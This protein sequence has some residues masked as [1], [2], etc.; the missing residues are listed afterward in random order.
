MK[1]V[2]AVLKHVCAVL[3]SIFALCPLS[4]AQFIADN[5]VVSS[6]SE[7]ATNSNEPQVCPLGPAPAAPW[8]KEN[9]Q[10]FGHI[11]GNVLARLKNTSEELIS[12][13]HDS[14]LTQSGVDPLW[15]GEYFSAGNGAPQM[16]FGV[17]CVFHSDDVP[18]NPPCD[19]TIFAN[20]ISPLI[21]SLAV[22]GHAYVTLKGFTGGNP[23]FEFDLPARGD[24]A[25]T[26]TVAV[27]VKAWLVAAD[28]NLLPY[29]PV[30][31]K[32]YLEQAQQE[33]NG[34]K[35]SLIAD[36]KSR[37]QV[38]PAAEQET[39]K[40]QS[41]EQLRNTYSGAELQ[42]R[43]R[44]FLSSYKTDEEYM[45]E[46]VTAATE[47]LDRTLALIGKLLSGSSAQQLAQPAVVS[48]PSLEFHGFEDGR[49]G[50]TVL[51]RLRSAYYSDDADQ[52]KSLLIC[53]RYRPSD[54]MAAAID[55]Q[56]SMRN[57]VPRLRK[58]FH[59]APPDKSE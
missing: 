3:L 4:H 59:T 14:V 9:D 28:S 8:K 42:T 5:H 43:T 23:A 21:G 24:D 49:P 7:E 50:S 52:V 55:R 37:I 22:N 31:R 40:Q 19:L 1:H 44:I 54:P 47:E 18:T 17:S 41:L 15:H 29:I 20:D 35:Q 32:E 58:Q 30:T 57:P 45:G 46:H 53:W 48:V 26:D 13:F 56:L 16:R 6:A 25:G 11:R 36:I 10:V 27:H 38:R 34:R 51:V 33:L 12:V 2:Y 39:V